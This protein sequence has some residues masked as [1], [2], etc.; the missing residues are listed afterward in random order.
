MHDGNSEPV[1]NLN[2]RLL[3]RVGYMS[4][5]LVS[6]PANLEAD[7]AQMDK[8]VLN[9]LATKAGQRYEDFDALRGNGKRLPAWKSNRTSQPMIDKRQ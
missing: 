1:I 9:G 8:L 5:I 3:T 6:D 2:T 4:V 7:A